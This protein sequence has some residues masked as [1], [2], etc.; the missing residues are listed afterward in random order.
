MKSII[1]IRRFILFVVFGLLSFLQS[2]CKHESESQEAQTITVDVALRELIPTNGLTGDPTQGRDLPDIA[3]PLAQLGM[4]LFFSKALGGDMNV[5]CV[6]CHH[7]VLGGGDGLSLPV[8]VDAEVP[9]LLGIGRIH[10]A[11]GE[12]YDGGP[13]VPRNAPTTFNIGLWD[14]VMFHDGRIESIGG[15]PGKN[16]ADGQGIRTPESPFGTA[17]PDSG[18]NLVIAQARFPVTSAEEMKDFGVMAGT[19][20]AQVRTALQQRLGDYGTP[21]GGALPVNQWLPLFQSAF[22]QPTANAET[23]ITFDNIVLAIGAYERSQVFVNTPWKRYV[24]GNNKALSESAKRG[25]LLFFASEEQGGAACSACH[26][27]D[28]F[29]D[30][31]FHVVA[32]PQIGR[33]KGNGT[34][35]DDDFG[36]YRETGEDADRYA[37]RTPSLLNVAV[38]GPWGHAGAYTSLENTVR[39]HL[40]P[41]LALDNYDWGQIDS[42]IQVDNMLAN[43]QLAVD[44]LESNRLAG[45]FSLQNIELNDEQINDLVNFL[46]A[47]TDSCVATPQCIHQWVPASNR[48]DPDELRLD[49][50]DQNN[51]LL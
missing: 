35:G 12:N 17:D 23:L 47:L 33:G 41:Q 22:Q 11:L 3:S 7:P 44:A 37:F 42:N 26:S 13:T 45:R 1:K 49:A 9:D 18:G 32:M 20:N 40:N 48:L 29:T 27:G 38:T 39:H 43:T 46:H 10:S 25:A 50:I 6:A 24:E 31:S 36:R 34:Y 21:P 19:T 51:N 2:G 4:D 28:F 14:K 16:G 8:G 30:E 15:T 5:A